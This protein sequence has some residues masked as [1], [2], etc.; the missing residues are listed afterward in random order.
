MPLDREFLD[1][2]L[3]GDREFGGELFAAF[4]EAS[5]QW[6]REAAAACR[7]G[8]V[9]QASRAFHTLKGSAG[10]V[11]LVSVRELAKD[12]ERLA[13]AGD[14][15]ACAPR[16]AELVDRVKEGRAELSG[17]LESL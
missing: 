12:L 2:L 15:P 3:D 5:S 8:D 16:L 10:S 11:G 17:F 4:D 6:L 13:K 1:E 14:L 9:E 7:S